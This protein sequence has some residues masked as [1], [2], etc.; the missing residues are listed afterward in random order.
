MK[1]NRIKFYF[2]ILVVILIFNSCI[3]SLHPLYTEDTIY[4]TTNIIGTW[5]E[6]TSNKDEQLIIDS[7][8][9]RHYKVTWKD[10]KDTLIFNMHLVMLDGQLYMDFY[11]YDKDYSLLDKA[12]RNFIPV[13]TFTKVNVKKNSMEIV[14]FDEDRLMDL[15]DKN[16]IR[17]GHESLED[18]GVV[19]T[20]SSKDLQKFIIKYSNNDEAFEKPGYYHKIKG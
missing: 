12:A 1:T 10:G 3:Y 20:A 9:D 2:P 16:R 11:P 8:S 14:D 6:D 17:L 15:F 18:I 13:H 19:I 4:F 7:L 5:V